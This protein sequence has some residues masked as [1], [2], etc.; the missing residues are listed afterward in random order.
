[1]AELQKARLDSMYE[2]A[3]GQAMH[4]RF[5]GAVHGLTFETR[6]DPVRPESSTAMLNQELRP[7]T[8]FSFILGA[9]SILDVH[10]AIS[11]GLPSAFPGGDEPTWTGSRVPRY[12]DTVRALWRR[13]RTAFPNEIADLERK[14]GRLLKR[15]P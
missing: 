2:R 3:S 1:M 11:M 6:E 14:Y 7:E 9:V 13:F 12:C 10:A 15:F 8:A 5:A 4:L